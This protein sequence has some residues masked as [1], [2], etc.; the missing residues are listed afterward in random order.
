M[1]LLI[2]DYQIPPPDPVYIRDNGKKVYW[3]ESVPGSSCR[4]KVRSK[5]FPGVA[6]AMA[7]QFTNNFYM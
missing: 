1:P 4:A 2:P 6:R 7:W 3:V 5:T